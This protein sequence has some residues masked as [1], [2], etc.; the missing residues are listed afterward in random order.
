MIHAKG[1]KYIKESFLESNFTISLDMKVECGVEIVYK[2]AG[3]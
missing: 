3:A 2:C 1:L